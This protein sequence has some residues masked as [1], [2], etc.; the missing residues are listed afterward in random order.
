M[1]TT[2]AAL[3]FPGTN[4]NVPVELP[5][6]AD[7]LL[8]NPNVRNGRDH[9]LPETV[10]DN[11]TPTKRGRGRPKLRDPF[12]AI[13][14]RGLPEHTERSV[15]NHDRAALPLALI[16]LHAPEIANW[17]KTP[18]DGV[19][20]TILV[21]LARLPVEWQL[22]YARELVKH[23]PKAWRAVRWLRDEH[24]RR[25]GEIR[26]LDLK[27]KRKYFADDRCAQHKCTRGAV[28]GTEFCRKHTR[29]VDAVITAK[30][31]VNDEEA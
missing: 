20:L 1:T 26:E 17:F 15:Y 5:T 12:R 21:A 7:G 3:P 13:T 19:K 29:T 10:S 4:K 6:L 22:G 9:E 23:N 2:E 30:E 11:P 25:L 14:R 28:E 31:P 18:R 27:S 8:T 24:D 16:E